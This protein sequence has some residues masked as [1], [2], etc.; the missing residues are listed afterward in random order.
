[1]ASYNGVTFE[2][3]AEDGMWRPYWER[4]ANVTVRNIPYAAKDDVQSA[5][6][7]NPRLELR[8]KVNSDANMDTLLASVGS[9]ARPLTNLFTSGNDFSNTYL[10]EVTD[11]RRWDHGQTWT[12]QAVFMRVGS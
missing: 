12:A 9:T 3:L 11:M 2:E 10:I 7:G 5:G 8:I 1:M 4:A 6:M